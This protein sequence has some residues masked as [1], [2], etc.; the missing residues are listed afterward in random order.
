MVST[1]K[2][3]KEDGHPQ[4]SF[5]HRKLDLHSAKK[6]MYRC[7][8]IAAFVAAFVPA[9]IVAW[10]FLFE[11]KNEDDISAS[12]SSKNNS[13]ADSMN[14]GGNLSR[15]TSEVIKYKFSIQYIHF[16]MTI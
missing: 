14:A 13:F 12:Q 6:I 5:L 8:G 16:M 2:E 9:N 15:L 1:V 4:W 3:L 10:I 7:L 11:V